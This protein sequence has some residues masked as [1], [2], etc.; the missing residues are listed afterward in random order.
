MRKNDY[1]CCVKSLYFRIKIAKLYLKQM[2]QGKT[3]KI[4]IYLHLYSLIQ[5]NSI[6]FIANPYLNNKIQQIKIVY[7]NN[8]T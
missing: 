5:F 6:Q 1:D 7:T 2:R 8:K 4:S 3:M